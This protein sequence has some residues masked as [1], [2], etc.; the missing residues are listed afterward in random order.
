MTQSIYVRRD[1]HSFFWCSLAYADCHTF[2]AFH[3]LNFLGKTNIMRHLA[4]AYAPTTVNT[5]F[6]LPKRTYPSPPLELANCTPYQMWS[7]VDGY[8]TRD[9][10][11]A[12]IGS[13]PGLVSLWKFD[14]GRGTVTVDSAAW[15]SSQRGGITRFG[16]LSP[17]VVEA[18][19]T[20]SS[21]LE[22]LSNTTAA[23]QVPERPD[24]PAATWAISTAPVGVM[25]RSD[26]GRPIFVRV[27]G[28]DAHARRPLQ[29]VL[30]QIP[31]GGTLSVAPP[32]GQSSTAG[33][34]GEGQTETV[35]SIG[36]AVPVGTRLLYRP[37]V[38][39]HD[40][41]L[42][43][44]VGE[45]GGLSVVDWTAEGDPYDWFGYRVETEGGDEVS[46][47]E[48]AVA[49]SVRPSLKPARLDWPLKVGVVDNLLM[50][51]IPR[52]R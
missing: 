18:A 1:V 50:C 19:P 13:E 23:D 40:P 31:T 9:P 32:V 28:T 4:N 41:W 2:G 44:S 51:C 22:S 48:A 5:P 45:Y 7:S 17:A 29:A 8:R 35:L 14:E 27:A 30:T 10:R 46:T 47:N 33:A 52:K 24:A 43:G 34:G 12:T 3:R 37:D 49:L 38:G 6:Q 15:R 16:I 21:L 42:G 11:D 26:D 36:D 39:A 20:S 25:V